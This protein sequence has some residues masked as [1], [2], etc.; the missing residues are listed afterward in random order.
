MN[1]F[2][3]K[4]TAASLAFA[5]TAS[6]NTALAADPAP[7]KTDGFYWIASAPQDGLYRTNAAGGTTIQLSRDA[8]L[9]TPVESGGWIYYAKQIVAP[10]P[11]GDPAQGQLYRMKTDGSEK[12]LLSPDVITS[13][14][15]AD[16]M[17]FYADYE[18]EDLVRINADGTDRQVLAQQLSYK[19]KFIDGWLYYNN[20][21]Y[22]SDNAIYRMKA[23]GTAASKFS[24]G[25][26]SAADNTFVTVLGDYLYY[27]EYSPDWSEFWFVLKKKDGT[28][29]YRATDETLLAGIQPLAVAN[30]KFYYS[31]PVEGGRHIYASALDFTESV[32]VT[33]TL[34]QGSYVGFFNNAFR[35]QL[36]DGTFYSIDL[37]GV[38]SASWS[39]KSTRSKDIEI[40]VYVGT[41]RIVF[42]DQSPVMRNDRVLVPIRAVLEKLGVNVAWDE[43]TD[44]IT[45][46]NSD[47]VVTLVLNADEAR[48]NGEIVKLD[49]PAI[50][51]NDRALVPI[52]FSTESFGATVKWDEENRIVRIQK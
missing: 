20:A 34:V 40:E 18:N 23:D 38:S 2:T 35:H 12:T 48:V 16:G 15:Y 39:A 7:A 32:Q 19:L 6:V 27:S 47:K 10:S 8:V 21:N 45:A 25:R 1:S 33:Q 36:A 13:F 52:R 17:V 9:G 49:Q 37:N 28:Q 46:S 44:T 22:E 11:D 29:V 26:F 14:D 5:L 30:G 43:D 31:S 24:D 41:E 51:L 3:R 50:T 42:K 4:L